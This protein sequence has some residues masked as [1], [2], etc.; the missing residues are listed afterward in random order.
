M[1]LSISLIVF[2]FSCV[3]LLNTFDPQVAPS[4][5]SS[6]HIGLWICWFSGSVLLGC[7]RREGQGHE[8]A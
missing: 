2:Y 1:V 6:A 5:N 4:A 7:S 8:I 3:E